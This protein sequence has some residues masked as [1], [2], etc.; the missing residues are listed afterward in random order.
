MEGDRKKQLTKKDADAFRKRWELVN[1]AEIEELRRTSVTKK[2]QQLSSLMLSVKELNWQE[3][4]SEGE[5]EVRERWN[6][7]RVAYHVK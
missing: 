5:A 1:T 3:P 6:R 2:L 4:L 7:L